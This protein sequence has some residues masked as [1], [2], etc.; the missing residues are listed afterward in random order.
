MTISIAALNHNSAIHTAWKYNLGGVKV[1]R[2]SSYFILSDR[3]QNGGYVVLNGL[4]GAIELINESLYQ[5]FNRMIDKKNPHEIYIK[6]N[7]LP[8]DI[9]ETFIK[10]GHITT[11]SHELERTHLKNIAEVF[12]EQVKKNTNIIIVPN[13]DCNYRCVYCF[14]KPLQAKLQT[15][16]TKMDQDNVDAVYYSIDQLASEIGD[17]SKQI[18]LFGGEPLMSSNLDIIQYIVDK[19]FK[20]GLNFNAVTNGH[21]LHMFMALL[22]KNKIEGLQITIDGVKS[23]HDKRRVSLDGTSSY[24]RII[25][26]T[27]QAIAETDV[28]IAIRV[29][30]DQTNYQAFEA[31]IDDFYKENWLNNNRISIN[32]TIVQQ[33][34]D[35]GTIF[36]SHDI[37]IV[38]AELADLIKKY[39]NISIGTEQAINNDTL[40]SS[41]LFGKPYR[42]RSSF[43]SA[44]SGMYIFLP[45]GN[46]SSCWEALD[47]EY[48]HIGTYSKN[49]VSLDKQKTTY[50]F[51]RS[52]AEIPECLDCKYC[53]VCAGGCARHA[54]YNS[55][56]IYKPYCGNFPQTYA[57]VLADAVE[58][59]L[60]ASGF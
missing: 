48:S 23:I 47:D 44:S 21:D 27:R 25:S 20:K 9:L 6:E 15:T 50:K 10:R 3:L 33:R 29:N 7:S 24:E 49:G 19:G 58:K 16:K 13:L 57:W 11:I 12:H 34:K 41:L 8:P 40:I 59:Y 60:K 32:A 39:S 53:L 1:L 42:L 56:D 26:N 4:S 14:E 43:C 28:Q 2:L 51:G 5:A 35:D 45:N 31:L 37:N 22:G 18:T 55:N 52:A 30:L 38:R 54:N 36:L 17:I 46:I